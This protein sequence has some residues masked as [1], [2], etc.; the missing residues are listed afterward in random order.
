MLRNTNE[1]RGCLK[2]A[3]LQD[4]LSYCW[5]ICKSVAI[6][7]KIVRISSTQNDLP[8]RPN[9]LE[10]PP[11]SAAG[12]SRMAKHKMAVRDCPPPIH[13]TQMSPKRRV[14]QK[15]W[16]TR[17]WRPTSDN[18]YRFWDSRHSCFVYVQNSFWRYFKVIKCSHQ[19]SE[20]NVGLVKCACTGKTHRLRLQ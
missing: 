10:Q 13:K 9:P 14:Q 20:E 2:S 12:I 3:V 7:A 15:L 1:P 5:H 16:M 8:H 19:I 6:T 11:E 4:C 18:C 17:L